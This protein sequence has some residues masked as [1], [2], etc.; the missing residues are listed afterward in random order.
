MLYQNSIWLITHFTLFILEMIKYWFKWLLSIEFLKY[1]FEWIWSALN[2]Y[3]SNKGWYRWW[4]F[5]LKIY[6][7]K[8]YISKNDG[9]NVFP[10]RK[11]ILNILLGIN[12]N[13]PFTIINIYLN[14]HC[15]IWS[16]CVDQG[17]M[18]FSV[19]WKHGIIGSSEEV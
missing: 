13:I 7:S 3:S 5:G 12:I 1:W 6:Y 2:E 19:K 8:T 14:V 18:A 16:H 17:L 9:I 4:N 10:A 15:I 11:S